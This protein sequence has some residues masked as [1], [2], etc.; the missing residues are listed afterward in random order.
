ML[1]SIKEL[2]LVR[3]LDLGTKDPDSSKQAQYERWEAMS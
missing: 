1:E 2:G 3:L